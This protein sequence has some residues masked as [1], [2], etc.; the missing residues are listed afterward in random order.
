MPTLRDGLQPP[1]TVTARGSPS[2]GRSG[3]G[4]GRHLGRTRRWEGSKIKLD[5]NR[6]IQ[7]FRTPALMSELRADAAGVREGPRHEVAGSWAEVV[8]RALWG[9]YEPGTVKPDFSASFALSTILLFDL[10]SPFFRPDPGVCG[11]RRAR[12]VKDGAIAPPAGLSLTDRAPRYAGAIEGRCLVAVF[13]VC[14]GMLVV[15]G[16]SVDGH[17]ACD[18]RISLYPAAPFRLA[19]LLHAWTIA[20]VGRGS[21]LTRQTG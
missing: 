20:Q 2:Q 17:V 19:T 8:Q 16:F 10:K 1:L 12:S 13:S 6:L 11:S 9:L 5:S 4:D 21:S 7:G 15:G 3:R 14:L 18:D